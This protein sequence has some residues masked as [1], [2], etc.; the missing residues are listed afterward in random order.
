MVKNKEL[1]SQEALIMDPSILL[2]DEVRIILYEQ[3]Y[4]FEI[5]IIFSYYEKN[6]QRYV[7]LVLL[8]LGNECPGCRE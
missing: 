7:P 1:P 4:T 2:L 8:N 6:V 5:L 3:F